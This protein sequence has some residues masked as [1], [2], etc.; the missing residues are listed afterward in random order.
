MENNVQVQKTADISSLVG[1]VI[2][3]LS[4]LTAYNILE[5]FNN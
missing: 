1:V 3:S 2:V 4:S 5:K